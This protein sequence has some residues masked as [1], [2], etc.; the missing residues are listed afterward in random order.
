MPVGTV[1]WFNTRKGYGFIE[2]ESGEKDAFVHITAVERAGL[3]G[4]KEGQKIEF[5]LTPDGR[6]RPTADNL[7][8]VE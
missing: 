6:G 5:E 4:L 1:K 2:Q 3:P 7:A 8:I